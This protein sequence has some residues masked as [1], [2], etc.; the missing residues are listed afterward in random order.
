VS[1]GLVLVRV[2]RVVRADQRDAEILGQAQQIGHDPALDRQP[3][4]HDLGEV[5][6]LAEDVL[7]LGCGRACGVVL[8]ESQPG[9]DLTGRATRRR[10][11]ALAVRLKKLA[12]HAGLE[13]LA[14][15]ARERAQ[16]EEVVHALGA[17]TPHGHVGVGTG[18][19]DVVALLIRGTPCHARLVA[20][21]RPRG[22]VGLEADDRFHARI[23]GRVVELEG[24][25]GVAVIGDGDGRHAVIGGRLRHRVDLGSTVQHRVLAVHV[26]VYEGVGCHVFESTS[27]RRRRHFGMGSTSSLRASA[28]EIGNRGIDRCRGC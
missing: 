2:V 16:P 9:L 20:A 13:V 24:R 4:I 26:Q 11:E 19:G 15:E 28:T 14:L 21:V 1:V 27:G 7:E 25:E 10:D 17:L 18:T 6:L 22:D 3:V 12:V 23:V 8:P 5:V